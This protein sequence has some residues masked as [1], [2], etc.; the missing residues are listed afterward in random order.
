MKLPGRF[1]WR[2]FLGNALLIAG[3]LGASVALIVREVE[4]TYRSNLTHRLFEQA[5]AL[6]A[7][8]APLLEPARHSELQS[9]IRQIDRLNLAAIRVTVVALDGRVLAD[10][11]GDPHLMESH[12]TRP[13]IVCALERGQGES[14]RWSATVKHDMK[15]V[16]ARVESPNGSPLGTVRVSM[17][18]RG[19]TAQT[20]TM[21]RLIWQTG[22]VGL[23][24]A[25]LLALGLAYIWSNPLQR[26]TETARTLSR[27]DLSARIDVAGNDEIAQVARSLN[28]MRESIARKVNTIERQ[29][30]N[31]EN[32]IRSLSEGVIVAGPDGRIVLMNDAACRLLGSPPPPGVDTAVAGGQL[33]ATSRLY[34]DL[35]VGR[36]VGECVTQTELV[37]FLVGSNEVR[38]IAGSDAADARHDRGPTVEPNVKELRLQIER[39]AGPVHLLAR[40]SEIGLPSTDRDDVGEISGRLVVLTDITELTKTIRMK[41]DF[42]ANASH[43]LRTPLS[44]IRAS[45]E[46]LE[47]MSLA[48]D[49]ASATSFIQVIARNTLR[50]EELVNDLLNLS[51]LE[52]A[53]TEFHPEVI[54]FDEFL[55]D[56]QTRFLSAVKSKG[57][58]WDMVCPENCRDVVVNGRLLQL[59]LD[60][61]VGNAVKFTEKGGHIWLSC[62]R[63]GASVSIEVRD[64][65]CGI[66]K[67]D[68]DRVF[69]RFYQVERARS[70][71]KRGLPGERGTGLG[72]SIVRHAVAA[73]HG[74]VLLKSQ[75]GKGTSVT[76]FLPQPA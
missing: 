20:A 39:T 48:D 36:P 18:V 72:L 9:A 73:M 37:E 43:E 33:N 42:V 12:G 8:L 75:P 57:L 50:L 27:G 11:E 5:A 54:E 52:S 71:V 3:V 28:R 61:L 4:S 7:E 41:T 46:T 64:D 32:L 6:K 21:T 53:A 23:A 30:K 24:A 49:P 14:E 66:P 59:V 76:I 67:E 22:A 58:H 10:T 44:T 63:L 74:T 15:Y 2:L 62:A 68:Q 56:L 51:R 70:G 25:I 13:E 19:I 60:N 31:L 45:I 17:P 1:F 26:I 65:G 16:A 40:C 55:A 69:E 34:P 38:D 47:Q 29:S 35:L